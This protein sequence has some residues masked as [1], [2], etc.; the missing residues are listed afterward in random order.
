MKSEYAHNEPQTMHFET[1]HVHVQPR[2]VWNA[3]VRHALLMSI[4]CSVNR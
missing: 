1:N 2:Y 3:K 4:D